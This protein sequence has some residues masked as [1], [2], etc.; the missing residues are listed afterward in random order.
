MSAQLSHGTIGPMDNERIPVVS[1]ASPQIGHSRLRR[2]LPLLSLFPFWGGII[3]GVLLSAGISAF[4]PAE[5]LWTN[6]AMSGFFALAVLIAAELIISIVLFFLCCLSA[7]RVVPRPWA[8]VIALG[9][10]VPVFAIGFGQLV[11]AQYGLIRANYQAEMNG[12]DL[13]AGL[14][15]LLIIAMPFLLVRRGRTTE[16]TGS[17][18]PFR[19]YI[20]AFA[21][22]PIAALIS[23]V[24][25]QRIQ[26]RNFDRQCAD[27]AVWVKANYPTP[28]TH[29]GLKLPAQFQALAAD[30]AVD[31][32][33]LPDGRVVVLLK[34]SFWGHDCSSGIVYSSGPIQPS[35]IGPDGYGRQQIT[36][37]GISSCYIE[38]KVDDRHFIVRFDLG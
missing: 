20:L 34:T 15:A 3:A 35:E 24:V 4:G 13:L 19:R 38:Q 6:E 12:F 10:V 21:A 23:S 25:I 37:P 1:Y 8:D 14:S 26:A 11:H 9:M 2:L 5:P 16:S 17:P 28:A 32:I 30:S 36:F 29:A 22:P 7:D 31:A 27:L 33:V 18:S